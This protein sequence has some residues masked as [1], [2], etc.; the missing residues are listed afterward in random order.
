MHHI[1]LIILGSARKKSDTRCFTEALFCDREYQLL[2]LLDHRIASYS[3]EGDYPA[4]DDFS[5]L[6]QLLLQHQLIVF[7]TPVYWYAMSGLMKVFFDRL[8]NLITSQKESGRQLMGRKTALLAV[9]SDDALPDGFT[10]PFAATSRYLGMEFIASTYV[11]IA[12]LKDEEYIRQERA[13][14]LQKLNPAHHA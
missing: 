11:P 7:A 1:P 6:C 12:R 2:D 5:G 3:Y 9:G 13:A 14:F 4:D 10:V 8:T